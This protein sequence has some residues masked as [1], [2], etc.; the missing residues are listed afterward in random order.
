M[1]KTNKPQT[2]KGFRDFLPDEK[3]KRDFVQNNIQSTFEAFGFKPIETPTIEYASLLLGK[4]GK[5]ADKLI[6]RFQDRGKR[7]V[8]LR[9]D[10]TIPTAR[11][12][13]QYQD[14]F[15]KYFRRYQIQNVFRADKPQKGRFREFTQCD[16]DIFN[17]ES[18]IAD[19]EIIA[20]FYF[21]YK[22]L[23]FKKI[24]IKYNDRKV[25]FSTLSQF[26]N[27]NINV[28]SLIQTI[29]KLDKRTKSQVIE[30][31]VKKG[32]ATQ[33]ANK[34]LD[35]ITN[36]QPTKNL[37]LIIKSAVSLGVPNQALEFSPTLARGLDYYTGLI[38]EGFVE[39]YQ[40]GSVGGGGRYDNL[41]NQLGG[42]DIKAV[43]FSLG[44]DRTVEALDQ[45]IKIPT[46]TSSTKVLV[47]IFESKKASLKLAN[48]LRQNQIN[49]EIFPQKSPIKKQFKYADQ[50]NIPFVC[51]IGP[52][53]LKT[54]QVTL[55]N[56]KS[57][58]QTTLP[59]DKLIPKLQPKTDHD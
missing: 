55:K 5:E 16:A 44:F 53:E 17:S 26:A 30:E 33:L 32:L 40:V 36:I 52:N 50:N 2:L 25:L 35:E 49:T 18:T 29:D 21:I 28:F 3:L 4:Y 22:N 15:P 38:F 56:M 27:K 59:L 8:A 51:V 9:Y 39:N 20:L 58:K 19:A 41:I 13:A 1:T 24:T 12:L 34:V 54:N 14:R 10:Q 57:G 7:D 42:A 31:L 11:V 37:S 46:T 43:G 48:Q 45:Q 23:G 6:Y 47:T